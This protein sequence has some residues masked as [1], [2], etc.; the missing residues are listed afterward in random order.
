MI[1]GCNVQNVY[2]EWKIVHNTPPGMISVESFASEEEGIQ[3][4]KEGN[5]NF[6]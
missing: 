4:L 6:N 3:A 5:Y 2:G 1:N